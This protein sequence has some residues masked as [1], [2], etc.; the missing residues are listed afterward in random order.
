MFFSQYIHFATG[1]CCGECPQVVLSFR[2]HS[3]GEWTGC[4]YKD[5]GWLTD[6]K[7]ENQ[8]ADFPTDVE[9]KM[10]FN[11]QQSSIKVIVQ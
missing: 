2:L 1:D 3:T 8:D 6:P 11:F 4:R 7:V 5:G 10:D 9:I